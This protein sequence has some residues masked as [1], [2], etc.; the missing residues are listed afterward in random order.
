MNNVWN[1]SQA[2]H[3]TPVNYSSKIKEYNYN[4]IP[5][6]AFIMVIARRRSGK[7]VL[8][9]DI[10]RT[11]GKRFDRIYLF[12]ETAHLNMEHPYPMIHAENCRDHYD[13]QLLENLLAQQKGHYQ[14]QKKLP[15]SMRKLRKY[16]LVLDDIIADENLRGSKSL[17]KLAVEG[18]HVG[19][20]V[21]LSSQT[22]SKLASVG[23]VI[24]GN[25]DI[26]ITFN[27]LDRFTLEVMSD[28]F[29]SLLGAKVG[30]DIIRT[31]TSEKPYQCI[32]FANY[33]QN[34]KSYEDFVYKKIAKIYKDQPKLIG[35]VDYENNFVVKEVRMEP[36]NKYFKKK[37][38]RININC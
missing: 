9:N 38:N 17:K 34:V 8:I 25:C 32:V 37:K 26:A 16:C 10:L 27:I 6:D 12:S 35:D 36:K 21:I 4:D 30:Q 7:T 29:A 23:R 20:T 28:D 18:R 19:I 5:D 15:E 11:I 3:R 31:I 24:F 33:S 2:S 14:N 1:C 22:A 13:E